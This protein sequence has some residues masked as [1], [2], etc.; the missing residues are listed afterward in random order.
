MI[1]PSSI[2]I[3]HTKVIVPRRRD[4]LLTRPRLLEMMF[5]YLDKK[6]ILI[7]APAGYG[8]SSL[9]IDL[10]H[11]TDLPVCWLSLD[12]LDRDPQRFVAYFIGA[13]AERF[14]G[15]GNQTKATLNTL[16]STDEGLEPL[17]VTLVNEIYDHIPEHYILIL[18]DYHLISDVP[19][20]Q[21]FL[22][23][24]VQLVDENCHLVISS[25][26]LTRVPDLPLMV[27]RD[28]VGGLDL[29]ELAFRSDEIQALFAK[30]YNV[31]LSDDK[32][33]ELADETEGWITGLQLSTLGIAQ[34]MADR[35]RVARAA[36][37][38][39]FDYLGL[40]V[41]DQQPED[42]KFFLL[43]SSLL[44]EF[45]ADL[46]VEVFGELYPQRKDWLHWVDTVIQSNLFALPVGVESG[47]VRYH[48]LFRD[49]LQDRLSKEHPEEIPPILGKLAQAYEA[50]YEW[51]KAY[52]VQKRL[53]DI[54]ALAGL[55]ERAA[56][57]LLPRALVTL[58]T[59]LNNLPPSIRRKKPGL[60]SVQGIIAY[61]KG[62]LRD[63]LALLNQAENIFRKRDDVMG[64]TTTLVRRATAH[65]FLGDYQAAL[66]DA[67][68]VISLTEHKDDF[69][70]VF[71]DALRQKG[72]SLF[73]QGNARQ[74]VRVLEHAL[75]IFT[76]MNDESQIPILM[77]ETGMTYGVLGKEE[78]TEQLYAQALAIWK[79][80]GN[81]SWQ[82]TLLNNL[83]VLHYLQGDYDKAILALEDGLL[84]A[85][86]GGYYVRAEALLLTSLGD[87]YSEVED[88][89]LAGQYYQ[90]G[91][92]I[93]E[94]I[95]DRFLLNY[96]SLAQANL[97][98]QESNLD[99]A[100]QM[101]D[102]VSNLI[103][104]DASQYENGLYHLVRGQLLLNEGLVEKAVKEFE[105]AET[106]FSIGGHIVEC[107]KSQIWLAA[108][109][110][111]EKKQETSR[112][113][114]NELIKGEIKNKY[115]VTIF[116]RQ[117]QPWLE[118]L[119][120]DPEMGPAIRDLLR[121]SNRLDSEM[122]GIR[123]RIRRLARTIEAPD[124]KITIRAFG[125]SQVKVGE[126]TL[127]L[128]D[129]QTQSVRDLFFYFLTME[130]P[131]TKEQIWTM[132]WPEIEEP[133]RLKVRFK[134]DLYRL[135]RAVGKDIVLFENDLYSFNRTS[136][137]EYDL[138]A[139]EGY[140][141]QAELAQEPEM[142]IELYQKAVKLVHGHFLEDVDATWVL[143]ERERI[144]QKF[145]F[146][147]LTLA[148][149][150]K[151]NNQVHEALAIY[152][153]AIEYEP[154]F[155]AAYLAS[156]KIYIQLDNRMGE[157]KLYESYKEMMEH[158][159]DLPPSPEVEALH[160]RLMN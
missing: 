124:A 50:H 122:P 152:Q 115:P 66:Q 100:H 80:E 98:I 48:H 6:L 59:W 32:A 93:A 70:L 105:S 45:D 34:G 22:S 23:R 133:S 121:K 52:H 79:Q 99:T 116:I 155:E 95:G 139:F 140:L 92:E 49:F 112:Q 145:L 41:L 126:K 119:Q 91:N 68:E 38:G 86:R 46:C 30:N 8:K 2:P 27:A 37:V 114:I 21:N 110:F 20:I 158:E 36:G 97:A 13:M 102:E 160:K 117:T 77:M 107:A 44:E 74:S 143:P 31:H 151:N 144:N 84:C 4:E 118:G 108:S 153:Q 148:D 28:L 54:D 101:L 42:I 76:R 75:E 61:M 113:K 149:L 82:A 109:Y 78:E 33:R 51:E 136:D 87:V 89:N 53:E 85:K 25:R 57:Y 10:S 1:T 19:I 111:Q 131:M 120:N 94:E 3:S 58:E 141:Y 63:G 129:W 7:S 90:Q 156:L 55:I 11:H 35:L 135:R 69:Q 40:Q 60:L 73:R 18:D 159:L 104:S 64:L 96:L 5:E 39:L 150:L 128:S 138:E 123:R 88:F 65:R 127:T 157:L 24:F 147:L 130:E 125:R 47:W 15:V 137:H 56:P 142:Q 62:D 14:P 67:D 106:C 154:T 71:A 72:L 9:L 17:V 12:S 134:N 43:R 132:F 81:L 26:A 29:S 146:T 16:T 83:G 103:S